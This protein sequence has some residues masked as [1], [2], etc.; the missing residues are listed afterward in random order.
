MNDHFTEQEKFYTSISEYYSD[1]FP[2]NPDQMNFVR[3]ISGGL[4]KMHILDLG[5][6]TGELAFRLA[7]N[8]AQVTAIDLNESFISRAG[9]RNNHEIA[10]FR[11]ADMMHAGQLF[12]PGSF[13]TVLCFGNT[14]VHLSDQD[15]ISRLVADVFRLLK[16]G[17]AFLIQ[18][19]N[20]DYIL[21]ARP[22]KL[23]VI[24]NSR[25]KFVRYYLYNQDSEYIRFKTVLT[26]KEGRM[27]PVEN[28]TSLLPL[29]SS[30]LN[31]ILNENG[32]S[33]IRF[34]SGFTMGPFGG[35]HL[36]M[37]VSCRKL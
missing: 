7:E 8:G 18:I 30:D 28:E 29:K 11:V 5:C 24:E 33:E 16:P 22:E 32:F 2:F 31:R 36:P 6:G 10:E 19:L 20:Y 13:D 14:L 23:P 9:E 25:L 17:G 3:E 37:V 35:N 4:D 27:E 26:L 15:Q 1:L 34:F 21:D 12:V